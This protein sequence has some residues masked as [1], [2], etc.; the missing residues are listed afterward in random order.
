[1][2]TGT[3]SPITSSHIAPPHARPV[4]SRVS[5]VIV[6]YNALPFLPRLADALTVQTYRETELVIVDSASTDGTAA[7]AAALFPAACILASPANIGYAAGNN[8]AFRACT[9]EYIA[10]LNPDTVPEPGWLEPLVAALDA[11]ASLGIV[12]PQ[13]VLD[14]DRAT[15]N[16]CGNDVHLAG[17]ATCRGLNAP[18]TATAYRA[19]ADVAAVSGAAFVARR[20]LLEALGGF[21]ESF[22][23][24]VEDTDL[25]W[26]AWLHGARC[27]YIPQ[28]V[29]AHRYAL[30]VG[31]GKLFYLERNRW[32]MLLKCYRARTLVALLPAL[33]LGELAVWA[34][35][36]LH[37]PAYLREKARAWRWL[38]ANRRTITAQRREVQRTRICGDAAL[39]THVIL[40]LPLVGGRRSLFTAAL[41]AP[42][43]LCRRLALALDTRRD[44]E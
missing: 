12:T 11:D 33:V 23:L 40:D 5:I 15:I 35:A 39:L 13:I 6:T 21:D 8:R 14:H 37:G 3:T 36:A 38:S 30:T 20:T 29:V 22:F 26:R 7:A 41:A 27:R 44:A 42:F 43:A 4:V 18:A 19:A 32:H 17:F 28:S 2:S 10:V 1:M 34:Y 16:T 24:Y 25:S 31:A 9:G